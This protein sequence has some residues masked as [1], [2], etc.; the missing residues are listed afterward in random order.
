MAPSTYG[1]GLNL[2]RGAKNKVRRSSMPLDT[3]VQISY[4]QKQGG[5]TDLLYALTDTA[6]KVAGS[7][8]QFSP[9]S[10]YASTQ[11]K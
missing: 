7:H 9:F 1:N 11:T 2:K 4:E 6:Q 8:W 3:R 5:L 10:I